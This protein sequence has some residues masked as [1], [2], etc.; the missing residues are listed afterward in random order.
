M[1]RRSAHTTQKKKGAPLGLPSSCLGQAARPWRLSLTSPEGIDAHVVDL[2]VACFSVR[3][4]I[5]FGNGRTGNTWLMEN[6]EAPPRYEVR[7]ANGEAGYGTSLDEARALIAD[8]ARDDAATDLFPAEI[9]KA[10]VS[11][12]LGAGELVETITAP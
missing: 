7:Y 3:P 4:V 11:D 12:A 10:G 1:L 9:R 6:R 5:R 8:K 2:P